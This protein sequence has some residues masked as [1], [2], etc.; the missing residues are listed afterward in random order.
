MDRHE[1]GRLAARVE[2]ERG[3]HA[4]VEHNGF[5][6]EWTVRAWEGNGEAAEEN[7]Y[8]FRFPAQWTG[9]RMALR[10]DCGYRYTFGD[11]RTPEEIGAIMR[12]PTACPFCGASLADG[13]EHS[14]TAANL[15]KWTAGDADPG[16]LPDDPR[17]V[18]VLGDLFVALVSMEDALSAVAELGEEMEGPLGDC[19]NA[20]Q[21]V[22]ERYWRRYQEARKA[23][24]DA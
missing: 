13:C 20:L 7:C 8:T 19:A 11:P 4:R 17:A 15:R 3:W 18:D 12:E 22:R 16:P 24:G 2:C 1:A 10:E 6:G 14:V 5:S 9:L 21:A 23:G